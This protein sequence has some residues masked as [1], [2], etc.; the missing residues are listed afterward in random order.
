MNTNKKN[1]EIDNKNMKTSDSIYKNSIEP[2][3]G[4]DLTEKSI[5]FNKKLIKAATP[6]D[7]CTVYKTSYS[8]DS[9]LFW[10]TMVG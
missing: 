7:E 8:S 2:N 9:V 4:D 5:L 1:S 10:F 3:K 6:I